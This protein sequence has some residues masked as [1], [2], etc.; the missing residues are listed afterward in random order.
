MTNEELIYHF[1]KL[2]KV[3]RLSGKFL[4]QDYNVAT[5]SYYTAL[6]FIEFAKLEKI[7]YDIDILEIILKHDLLESIVTDLPWDVKNKNEKTQK[8]WKTIEEAQAKLDNLMAA[9]VNIENKKIHYDDLVSNGH[10]PEEMTQEHMRHTGTF[11]RVIEG[12]MHVSEAI[13]YLIPNVGSP[14]AITYG[15]KQF[16]DNVGSFAE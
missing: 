3:K 6:L 16:G 8:A 15:G 11:L 4:I 12:S 5:H 13:A 1:R 9:K 14:F 7:K 2:S 10:I